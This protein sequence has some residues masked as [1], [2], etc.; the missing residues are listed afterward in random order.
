LAG[1]KL[2]VQNCTF[3]QCIPTL[4]ARRDSQL[5][6][7]LGALDFSLSDEQM[8]RLAAANPLPALYPHTFWNDYIRRDLIFGERVDL[9]D[10][11][12]GGRP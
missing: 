12:A 3:D 2:R 8:L 1:C 6:D 10:A 9:L 11:P 4:G 7:N 5:R